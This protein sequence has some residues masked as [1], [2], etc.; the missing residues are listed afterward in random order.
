MERESSMAAE[1]VV[2]S[3]QLYGEQIAR[4][5]NPSDLA[6]KTAVSASLSGTL[7]AKFD[8][9][10]V[11]AE[12]LIM[13][14]RQLPHGSDVMGIKINSYETKTEG[15]KCEVAIEYYVENVGKATSTVNIREPFGPTTLCA[16]VAPGEIRNVNG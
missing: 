16:S 10:L 15:W 13:A 12:G 8:S 14:L 1:A 6:G 5:F 7:T 2:R 9:Q 3:E 4:G 11:S